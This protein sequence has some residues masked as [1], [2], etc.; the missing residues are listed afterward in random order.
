[1]EFANIR[2]LSDGGNPVNMN[3]SYVFVGLKGAVAHGHSV[4]LVTAVYK[5]LGDTGCNRAGA[6]T[7][8]WVFIV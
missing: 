7:K 4:D 8:R 2:S 5:S 1:V 3:S 6:A